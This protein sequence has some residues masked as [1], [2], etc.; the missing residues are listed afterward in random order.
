MAFTRDAYG[1]LTYGIHGTLV[2]DYIIYE[3][4]Y[5]TASLIT[6]IATSASIAVIANSASFSTTSNTASFLPI[7]TYQITSSWSNNSR[8]ASYALN[9][10][11]SS[12]SYTASYALNGG[13]GGTTLT[14]G[15]TY[16]I[17]S[18]WS[19]TASFFVGASSYVPYIGAVSDVNL[20]NNAITASNTIVVTG[21]AP[22]NPL[23]GKLWWDTSDS[24]VA[25]VLVTS[26]YAVVAAAVNYKITTVNT[27]T[28]LTSSIHY[29][30]LVDAT[31]NQKWISLP[32]TGS[33]FG[34]IF[35]VKKTD[36]STNFVTLNSIDSAS[37]DGQTSI[38][39]VD[40]YSCI[41]VQNSGSN[42]WII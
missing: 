38:D 23:D 34:V 31:S 42:W 16:P 11:T 7:G 30:V 28:I 33:N 35:N 21:S 9:S 25:P 17:T 39:I 15:S 12:Y 32:P 27:N 24:S 5:I 26:S 1:R 10:L 14:T 19:N 22:L 13:G 20:G 18:S 8:T 3:P 41:T 6:G 29:T 36:A 37:I 40:R 2:E 4:P